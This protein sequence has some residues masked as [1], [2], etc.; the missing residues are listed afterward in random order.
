MWL[1]RLTA[2]V[3]RRSFVVAALEQDPSLQHDQR[4]D[5]RSIFSFNSL[6]A[7]S[8]RLS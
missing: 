4:F 8:A 6:S 3:Y 1:S 2:G 5:S 7:M